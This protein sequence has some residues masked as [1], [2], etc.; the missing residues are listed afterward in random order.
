MNKK[1]NTYFVF[2]ILAVITVGFL[3]WHSITI[4]NLEQDL[5]NLHTIAPSLRRSTMMQ[6]QEGDTQI[7]QH[8]IPTTEKSQDA[9]ILYNEDG[10]IDTSNWQE[11][12]NKEH[13]FCVKYPQGWKVGVNKEFE[14]SHGIINI[15]FSNYKGNYNKSNMPKDY[16]AYSINIYDNNHEDFSNYK[17]NEEYIKEL[18]KSQYNKFIV[19]SNDYHIDVYGIFKKNA[20]NNIVG[21]DDTC[22]MILPVAKGFLTMSKFSYTFQHPTEINEQLSSMKS[23]MGAIYTFRLK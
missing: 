2:A 22:D 7:S 9:H 21:Y 3:V 1:L 17:R 10:S 12:C 13:G 4:F 5:K 19:L 6:S 14:K 18:A 16:K 23:L 11:Y 20:C 8:V 15:Y